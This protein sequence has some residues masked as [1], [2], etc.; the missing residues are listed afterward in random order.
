MTIVRAAKAGDI[1][2]LLMPDKAELVAIRRTQEA[3][4]EAFGGWVVPEVHITC[5][6]FNPEGVGEIQTLLP[7]LIQR[8]G[9]LASFP[10][11]SD[12]LVQL[13]AAFWQT[14][15]LRWQV[16]ETPAW[17][18]FITGLDNALRAGGLELHYPHDKP[19]NCSALD[20]INPVQLEYAP[21]STYPRL[22][23][24]AG[25][26]VFSRILGLNDFETL[27]T[28]ELSPE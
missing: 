12:G 15:V 23:F 14:H 18:H 26:V 4:A 13:H 21:K 20:L 9:Q 16:Q 2:V 27:A 17:T 25:K 24:A 7:G 22:L 28:A 8:I 1:C 3:L 6:R 5:Q 11:F 19:F 10:I